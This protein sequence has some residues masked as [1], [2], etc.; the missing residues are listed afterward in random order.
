MPWSRRRLVLLATLILGIGVAAARPLPARADEFPRLHPWLLVGAFQDSSTVGNQYLRCVGS[1]GPRPDSL[2]L[3]ARTI[4]MRFLRNRLAE[5]RPDFGGYRIYRMVGSSRPDGGPDT[6]H[7]VLIRRF[8]LN[9]GSELTW[10]FSRLDTA[11][12]VQHF[13]THDTLI[14]GRDTTV[15][16]T[17]YT[18]NGNYMQYECGGAVVHDSVVTFVDPDSSGNYERLC[19]RRTPDGVCLSP[20]DSIFVLVAPPGPHDGIRTWY[21]ITYEKLNTTDNDFEDMFIPDTLETLGP[22]DSPGNRF[23]CRNLNNKLTNVVGPVEPTAGPTANLEHVRVVPNPY[24]ANEVWDPATAHELHFTSLPHH[25]VI[26]IYTVA[27][28]LVATLHHDD[29]IRDFERW[30]LKSDPGQDVASGIYIYRVDASGFTY[31]SRFIVIR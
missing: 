7:A 26:R 5:A 16:D 11:V 31:Q 9:P 23:T 8:S 1:F 13:T 17:T 29:M 18:P 25:A 15:S 24:R 6:T 20:K 14:A 21:S 28:D 19:R 2:R 4:S 27:G 3:Q 12:N 30:N 22:C 10:Q